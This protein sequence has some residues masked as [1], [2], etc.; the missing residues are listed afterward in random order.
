[1][2]HILV[3]SLI[4]CPGCSRRMGLFLLHFRHPSSKT[5]SRLA[6]AT[7]VARAPNEAQLIIPSDSV[8]YCRVAS[9]VV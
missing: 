7:G 8:K 2:V 5:S 6:R 9:A 3:S 1:M 4:A